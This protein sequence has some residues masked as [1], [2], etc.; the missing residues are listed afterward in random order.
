MPQWEEVGG[1]GAA[2]CVAPLSRLLRL[3]AVLIT[4]VKVSNAFSTDIAFK[5]SLN[6]T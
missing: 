3:Q 4:R 6:N 2:A 5:T 1:G